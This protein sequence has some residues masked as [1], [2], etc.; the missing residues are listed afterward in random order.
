MINCKKASELVSKK[1]DR[2]LS[3]SEKISLKIHN[4]ICGVC[5]MFETENQVISE[6]L[7]KNNK[8][9]PLINEKKKK[10]IQEAINNYK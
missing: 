7:K 1:I 5:T 6:C 3:F 4:I 10:E 9:I 2:R 8:N